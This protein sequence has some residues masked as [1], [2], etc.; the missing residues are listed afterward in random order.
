[1]LLTLLGLLAHGY[2]LGFEDGA[3]YLP[4]IKY[5]L[6]PAL[7]PHDSIFFIKQMRFTVYPDAMA[8][9]VRLSHLGLERAMFFTHVFSIF[10]VLFGCLRVSKKMFASPE[11]RWSS[12]TLIAALLTLP[13]AGTALML[14]HQHLHP[15]SL[16]AAFTLFAIAEALDGRL[17]KAA[18][19]TLPAVLLNPLLACPGVFFA[20]ILAWRRQSASRG[21]K[22][23][24]EPIFAAG[25]VSVNDLWREVTQGY[26]Y[27]SR[28][29]WYELVG[30]AAPLAILFSISRTRPSNT[31]P[32]FNLVVSQTPVFGLCFA[33]LSLALCAPSL[34]RLAPL[35]PMRAFHLVYLVLFLVIGGLVGE[36]V[37]KRKPLRWALF[38]LPIFVVMF[39]VQAYRYPASDHI[40]W[41]GIKPR[42]QWV[43]AFNWVRG[44]T[45][46]DA[47]FALDPG[48]MEIRGED[49]H[50]F[51]A[52]AERSRMCDTLKDK[53]VVSVMFAAGQITTDGWSMAS[54][55]ALNWHDQVTALRD[56]KNFGPEDFR[57]LRKRFGV[58]W[59]ILEKPE[60]S[61]LP[62]VY[63][64]DAVKVCRIE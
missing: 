63:E 16:A 15:R 14:V 45:P 10:L 30:L 62:C 59:V 52:L 24:I 2:H 38:F 13:V 60:A 50:G 58:G 3:V 18:V 31:L 17:L 22:E 6:D 29:T 26:F 4:A 57:R 8:L 46:K 5:H 21:A 43:Q 27:L 28:W 40:E 12:V 56:W 41:P 47:F 53:V 33:A 49:L 35:Q 36:Y 32:G 61:G 55:T 34:E 9:L 51:R 20:A 44:N 37:L 64:N 1:M 48:Y 11:A 19:W 42:N 23:Q 39:S 7:Y 25:A 54:E